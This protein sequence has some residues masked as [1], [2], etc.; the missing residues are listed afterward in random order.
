MTGDARGTTAVTEPDER[1]EARRR[2]EAEI[3]ARVPPARLTALADRAAAAEAPRPAH[4]VS[5]PFTGKEVGRIQ[6]LEPDDVRAAAVRARDAQ[7][8]WAELPF[9]DRAVI[10]LRFHDCI[11][12]RQTEVMDLV[13]VETGKARFHAF[14]EVV[15]VALVARHYAYRG[16]RLLATRRRRGAFP[17]VTAAW[18]R[19]VPKG[20][21]GIVST[22][23]Y[24][25]SIALS[26][27]LPALL[28]G[29]GV[30]LKPAELTPFTALWCLEQLEACGL[31]AGLFQVVNGSGSALGETVIDEVDY[32]HFTGSTTT[33][34][35][36]AALA[37]ERLTGC[38]LE[39]GGKNAMLVLEDADMSRAVEGAI[40]AC[41]SSA[42]QL[43][44]ASE[45]IH[46]HESRFEEFRSRFVERVE[47]MELG[48]SFDFG[49]D[50]GSLISATHLEKVTQHVEEA[51]AAGARVLTGGRPRPELGPWFY[52]PTALEGVRAGMR[53]CDEETFGPVVALDRFHHVDDVVR[54]VNASPFGL[55]ASVWTR[56]TRH[57]RAIAA[58]LRTGTVSINDAYGSTWGSVD[59]P[60]GGMKA[61]GLRR[62][63]GVEGIQKYTEAQTVAVQRLLP[64][65]IPPARERVFQRAATLFLRLARR[66][67]GLR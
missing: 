30:L 63:H 35:E 48:A 12:A 50:M 56:R 40:Q 27:A 28:A 7:R 10:V 8:A 9:R 60:M 5:A 62:R 46:V 36:V 55:N 39:L 47:A 33:G 42:G 31:P 29:N 25:L 26:D 32:I 61:S 13:Q 15:D 66:V 24:P 20:L 16:E 53:V 3:A 45:A 52:E 2:I 41:F 19:R 22:W 49:V 18:E 67:P 65:A 37:G 6:W 17:L 54:K 64:L 57:G 14:A 23:N 21:V 59:A 38:S 43:C 44:M 51:V 34:R 1:D 11:L 4:G 58:R